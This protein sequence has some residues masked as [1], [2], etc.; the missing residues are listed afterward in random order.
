[1]NLIRRYP[2]TGF[3]VFALLMTYGFG[4][5]GHFLLSWLQSAAGTRISGVNDIFMRFG[6]SIAGLAAAWLAFGRQHVVDMLARLGRLRAPA[7]VWLAV[8]LLAPVLT[9][10]AFFLQGYGRHW[11]EIDLARGL[12]VFALNLLAASFFAG[13]GEE[14]GW[15]GFL[16]PL[17]T[18]RHGLLW[19]SLLTAAAWLAWHVPAYVLF[20]KGADDPFLPF[21][22]IVLPFSALLAWVYYRPGESLLFPVLLHGAI[23]ASF[24]SLAALFPQVVDGEGF[25]PGFDWT[26]AL[27]WTGAAALI[28]FFRRGFFLRHTPEDT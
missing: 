19:A 22:V 12:G 25:Q 17:L 7:G 26:L 9:A 18:R 28:C 23:N 4:I 8:L 6:P 24:Y 15:R 27:L 11:G 2:A 10:T 21:A 16:Q 5:A 1:M 14:I 3:F 13:L 20:G